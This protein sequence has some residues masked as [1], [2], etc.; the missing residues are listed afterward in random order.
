MALVD[1]KNR[2][3]GLKKDLLDLKNRFTGFQ[4]GFTGFEKTGFTGF[5]KTG[6][7]GFEKTGFEKT[8]L[9]DFPRRTSLDSSSG[10]T[11]ESQTEIKQGPMLRFAAV[12][13]SI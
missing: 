11:R 1:L 4:N 5:E 7:T 10:V 9:P 6:F 13:T 3:T 8:D 12:W 2:F